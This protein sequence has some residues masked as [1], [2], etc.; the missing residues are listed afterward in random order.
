[1]LHAL[2]PRHLTD[3]HQTL[4]ALLEFDKGAIVRDADHA[5][6]YVS[7]DRISVRRVQPRIRGELLESQGNALF[8]FIE[9]EHLDLDL[10][11]YI[12]QV[13]RMR[14]PA[15]GHVGDMQQ[16]IDSA[17]AHDSSILG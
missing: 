11:T 7:A 3:V 2:G 17:Q 4:D 14:H 16:A 5:S 12:Y 6:A 1:M 15:P 9:F 13:S 8:V 10:I